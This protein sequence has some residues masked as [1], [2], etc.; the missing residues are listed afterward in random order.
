MM[1][2]IPTI[3]DVR[4]DYALGLEAQG[5]YSLVEARALFDAWLNNEKAYVWEDAFD[6]GYSHGRGNPGE[7]DDSTN[8][9]GT[10][11]DYR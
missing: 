4:E 2:S 6:S 11:E 1:T 9:Y 10:T 7:Y 5:G 3:E 8:P